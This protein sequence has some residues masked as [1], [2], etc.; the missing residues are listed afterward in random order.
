MRENGDEPAED[1]SLIALTQRCLLRFGQEVLHAIFQQALTSS[2]EAKPPPLIGAFGRLVP[3]GVHFTLLW[4]P[5]LERAIAEQQPKR[6]IYAIQPSLLS[7]GG[8]PRVVKRM[9]GATA[10]RMEPVLPRRFDFDNEIVVLRLYGGYSPE[11]RP[12]FSQPLLTEDD[13]IHGL[14]AEGF[15]PPVWMEELLARPRIQPGLFVGLSILDWRH[16]MLLC[17]L[18]DR[19]PAPKDSLAILPPGIDPNEPDFWDSGGGL[20]GTGRIAPITEDPAQLAPLLDAF[21]PEGGA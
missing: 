15:K 5:H 9:A 21:V 3:P 8:K 11:A 4:E 12:I 17:W 14:L 2:L 13:H 16:R 6:T 19:R 20:P 1:E 18:Y 7:A 10:W